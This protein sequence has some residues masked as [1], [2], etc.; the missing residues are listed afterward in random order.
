VELTGGSA[1]PAQEVMIPGV[2]ILDAVGTA[3]ASALDDWQDVI[4]VVRM[5]VPGGT[6]ATATVRVVPES[7]DTPGTSF[8]VSIP[9]GTVVELP[10][11]S[12]AE[13]ETVDPSAGDSSGD[14]SGELRLGDGSYTVF[15]DAD[16]PIVAGVRASTADD[17]GS[18]DAP[19][20][21]DPDTFPSSDLAWFASAP[22]LGDTTLIAVPDAPSPVIS[23]TNPGA[24]EVRAQLTSRA[25]GSVPSPILI[26]PGGTVS[27]VVPRGSVYVLSG[28]TGL[29]V[30]V[31]SADPGALSAFVV[32]PPRPVSG[33]IVIHSG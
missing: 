29:G 32:S 15:V 22:A 26:R 16:Q 24:D 27:I 7:A 21:T 11:D 18:S 5:A 12:V 23:I 8:N 14:G 3:R 30:A 10:L 17:A 25:G 19:D 13:D 33:P 4:P 9:A 20:A 1:D 31:T 28:G 6:D 2:R